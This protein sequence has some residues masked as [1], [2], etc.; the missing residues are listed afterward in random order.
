MYLESTIAK[1]ST[2]VRRKVDAPASGG[3]A[4]VYVD[5]KERPF[6]RLAGSDLLD[7]ADLCRLYGVSAR[8]IYR[9]MAEHNLRPFIKI[10]REYLFRKDAIIEWHDN[11]RPMPGRPPNA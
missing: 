11:Y 2:P 8:T 7:T 4:R 6:S 1:N 5:M 10:G 3:G 9:W